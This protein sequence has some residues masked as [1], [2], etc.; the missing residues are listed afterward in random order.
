[1]EFRTIS[2]GQGRYVV[3]Q[4]GDGPEIVLLHGFPDTP[5][6]WSEVESALVTAGWHVTVPWLR[7]Y[8]PDTIVPGRRYDPETIGRTRWDCST[9]STLRA[10]CS[11][12]TIG[13][14]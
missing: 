6:S 14:R 12:G 1:M 5:Y 7:G 4:A 10:P 8:H 13:A 9:R 2:S 3:S 11:W